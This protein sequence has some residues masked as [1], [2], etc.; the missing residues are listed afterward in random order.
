MTDAA[1]AAWQSRGIW[2]AGRASANAASGVALGMNREMLG[3]RPKGTAKEGG[4]SG[5]KFV[6]VEEE[7]ATGEVED[8]IMTESATT[9]P[10]GT[11][12]E[13]GALATND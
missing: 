3:H 9:A 2:P 8:V 4:G 13:P 7:E 12:T 5:A 6:D 1:K 11:E 10:A